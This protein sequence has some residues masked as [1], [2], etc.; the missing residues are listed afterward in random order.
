MPMDRLSTVLQAHVAGLEKAGTAKGAGHV[1]V[2]VKLPAGDRGARFLLQGQG[3]EEIRTQVNADH[4]EADIDHVL[5]LPSRYK[6][7]HPD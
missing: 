5:D 2:A 1:V 4:T 6:A 3:D 7:Q